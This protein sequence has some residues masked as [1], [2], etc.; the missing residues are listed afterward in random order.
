VDTF[1][2]FLKV[3]VNFDKYGVVLMNT[4]DKLGTGRLVPG[5]NLFAISEILEQC[6]IVIDDII[7]KGALISLEIFFDCNFDKDEK[8]DPYPKFT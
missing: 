7:K 3:V 2:I 1:T 5:Y 6:G 4:E 8:C